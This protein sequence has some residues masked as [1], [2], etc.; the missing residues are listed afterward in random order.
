MSDANN[1]DLPLYVAVDMPEQHK[2]EFNQLQRFGCA[3][4]SAIYILFIAAFIRLMFVIA[5]SKK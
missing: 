5:T 2:R 4:V 1:N 3:C